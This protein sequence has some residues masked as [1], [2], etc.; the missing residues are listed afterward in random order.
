MGHLP[1][2]WVCRDR[3]EDFS[4]ALLSP[5]VP[6]AYLKTLVDFPGGPFYNMVSSYY[7]DLHIPVHA[8]TKGMGSNRARKMYPISQHIHRY[9]GGKYLAGYSSAVF[10][11]ISRDGSPNG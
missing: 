7:S 4:L 9:P 2:V 6:Y 1:A 11:Y 5:D 3:G 10:A 8:S